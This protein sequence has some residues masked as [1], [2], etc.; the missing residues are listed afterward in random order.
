MDPAAADGIPIL[1]NSFKSI[2]SFCS[3]APALDAN[4]KSHL[5]FVFEK[6]HELVEEDRSI[7]ENNGYTRKQSFSPIEL[8]AI[9]CLIS[10]KAGERPNGMLKG[11]ILAFR[12]H[13]REVH[14]DIRLN[15]PCWTT[16]WRF[17]DSIEHHRGAIDGST[18][19][20]SA[21]KIQKKKT[22]P[23]QLVP[24]PSGMSSE[25]QPP[26]A[27]VAIPTTATRDK[28]RSNRAAQQQPARAA[29]RVTRDADDG[30]RDTSLNS[31]N[32]P[33]MKGFRDTIAD[34]GDEVASFRSSNNHAPS[35]PSADSSVP[36][37]QHASEPPRRTSE[38]VTV[39]SRWDNTGS[40]R[41]A[42]GGPRISA[43][44]SPFV[45]STPSSMSPTV[46]DAPAGAGQAS[47]TVPQAR[48]RAALDLGRGSGGT[49]E[50]ESKRA[51]LMSGY[52]KQESDA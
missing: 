29:S 13:L 27:G 16:A 31:S 3:N 18:S 44:R 37:E 11:D 39:N 22:Q 45:P 34:K 24:R 32:Y 35:T 10:Q 4:T 46:A 50:L 41:G 17:I 2:E 1:R 12:A 26:T 5:R 28:D 21:P 9:T 33:F 36:R 15:K 43:S 51:R 23:Q 19:Q 42:S 40:E 6:F 25:N 52:V 38:F 49:R 47:I 7:F 14:S 30:N 8:I 20:R 48:K